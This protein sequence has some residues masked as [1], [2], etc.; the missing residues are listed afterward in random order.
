MLSCQWQ[1]VAQEEAFPGRCAEVG[2]DLGT[3]VV[4]AR[5]VR[6]LMRLCLLMQRNFVPYSKWLGSAF[7][8]LPCA[9]V[10]GPSLTRALAAPTWHER[11]EHLGLAYVIV[12]EQ[13]NE[14]GL[15]PPLDASTR[16]YYER[17]YQ[18][19][20]A[21]RFSSALQQSISRARIRELPPV[22]NVDQ[23]IDS[24][25]VLSDAAQARAAASLLLGGLRP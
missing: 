12:A 1:R 18:V 17:P 15:T 7:N 5:L 13:H 9:A 11:E 22:G 6:D 14:L 20:E 19:I 23:F 16:N 10:L 21:G 4:I 25:D 24:T 8:A 2:D 3:R